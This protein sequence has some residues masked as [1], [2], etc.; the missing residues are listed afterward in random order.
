MRP[1]LLLLALLVLS[2]DASA[3]PSVDYRQKFSVRNRNY[4][5]QNNVQSNHFVTNYHYQPS[6][7]YYMPSNN[8]FR[9]MSVS[10]PGL[11]FCLFC[12]SR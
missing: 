8:F 7:H 2:A 3:P 5:V 4:Y 12:F 10:A 6:N 1:L 9:P 11:D